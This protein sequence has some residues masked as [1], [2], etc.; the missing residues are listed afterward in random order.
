MTIN[1]TL[2][3]GLC[4]AALLAGVGPPGVVAAHGVPVTFKLPAADLETTLRTFARLSG[5]QIL[6]RPQDVRGYRFEGLVTPLAADAALAAILRG[7]G[8]SM[9]QPSSNVI[10]IRNS[11]EGSDTG[12]A[13]HRQ[14]GSFQA[15]QERPGAE[16]SMTADAG[17]DHG[18]RH[19][20]DVLVTG[21]RIRGA[22]ASSPVLSRSREEIRD[23]GISN[24]GD[25]ART[26]T[27]NYSGGQ[28]PGVS[29]SQGFRNTNLNNSSALNLRGLGPDA[30]LTLING[31]R[32]AYDGLSQ[33]VDISAI[34]LAAITR[35]EIVADGASA[36]YGS[37]A[38]GG[39]ANVILRRDFTGLVT[40]ARLG[41][42]TDGG[43]E[44][45]QYNA[46]VGS[47]W[48]SG[49]IMAAIDYTHSTAITARN[50][51]YTRS[52][53]DSAT[54]SPGQRQISGVVAGHQRLAEGVELEI[55]GQ[56]SRRSSANPNPTTNT[57]DVFINGLY[58]KPKVTSYTVTPTLRLSL[59]YAWAASASGTYGRSDTNIRSTTFSQGAAT[60]LAR[61]AYA[62]EVKSAEV[63]AEGPLFP[64]GGGDVR[65]AL[66]AGYRS[67]RLDVRVSR[68]P[69]G[70]STAITEQT[71][72]ARNVSFGYGEVSAPLIGSSNRMPL[73]ESLTLNAALRYEHYQA[74]GAAAAPKLGLIYKPWPD[75]MIR[76]SWGRSYKV[77]TLY[78]AYQ[79]RYGN[80][81]QGDL[82]AGVPAGKAVLAIA[83]GNTALRPERAETWTASAAFEPRF[84]Q[85][86]KVEASYF[87][88]RFGDRVAS[89]LTNT[90]TAFTDP[91]N[92]EIAILNPSA[93]Q[94]A[95]ALARLPQG[96][97]NFTGQPDSAVVIGGIIDGSL[98]NATAQ[99]VRGVDLTVQYI[100][101]VGAGQTLKLTAS[102]S[103][104]QSDQQLAAGRP[105]VKLTGI[106]FNPPHW[107]GRVGATYQRTNF[108][109]SA[110]ASYIGGTRDNRL[111]PF[112][113]VR[114]F[115]TFDV[116]ARVRS[117]APHGAFRGVDATLA[118]LNLFNEKPGFVRKTSTVD[119]PY[120]TTNASVAGRVINLT[121][122]KVW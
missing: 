85:G 8:L 13:L 120:D 19:I 100:S 44:Q 52:L 96:A 31:H 46:V 103:Y 82:F 40:S 36:L 37:D 54:L 109:L 74:I 107:R 77:P 104:Q 84:A 24:L 76:A 99:T 57:S 69:T 38:V 50:R 53:D 47:R 114:A 43:N 119:L 118:V 122:S 1:T 28:N 5:K 121:L 11:L 14:E 16:A 71:S 115:K 89:P 49:G 25:F 73:I 112:Q 63:T 98:Q 41:A 91:G 22:P 62:N 59:P 116:V 29:S 32:V 80:L 3:Q 2:R 4:V 70:G 7:T 55:D 58:P 56:Y 66:G 20:D 33:G 35:V 9:T 51:D 10:V 87:D 23:A 27:E 92:D 64:L 30:T 88:I 39:V 108:G 83:G 102:T 101:P 117:S 78:Q 81:V 93:Q 90:L 105:V 21:S 75:L 12:S 26:L 113:D 65:L 94:I 42:S 60:R 110:I 17:A 48:T 97:S 67:A 72:G 111:Q 86:L 106:V 95:E 61:L 79:I 45:Q 6:F 34:P 15:I 68:T 18:A